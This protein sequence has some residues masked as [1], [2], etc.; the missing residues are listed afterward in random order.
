MSFAKLRI[1]GPRPGPYVLGEP[2]HLFD[3]DVQVGTLDPVVVADGGTLV[4]IE[5][6]R[7]VHTVSHR[8]REIGKL[9]LLEM[10]AF[11]A[12]TF[13]NVQIV[14]FSLSRAINSYGDGMKLAG[15]R[16][17][18]L[19]RIGAKNIVIAPKPDSFEV[20]HFMV[21]AVWEYNPS[22]LAALT[23]ALESEREAYGLREAA[24]AESEERQD[25]SSWIKKLFR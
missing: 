20:G 21:S 12:E 15:A 19:Y 2:M 5:H 7:A 11:I 24:A 14:T 10:V 17:E 13:S 4:H 8:K 25:N 1:T 16:S 3:G 22:N 9:A 23:E 18:L 6:F